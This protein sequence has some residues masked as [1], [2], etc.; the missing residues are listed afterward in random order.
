MR[1]PDNEGKACDAVVKVLEKSTGETRSNIRCPEKDGDGPPVELRLMLGTQEFAIEHTR[2]E[3]FEKQIQTGQVFA[4]VSRLIVDKLSGNLPGPECYELHMPVDVSLRVKGAKLQQARRDLIEW[5]RAQ[6]QYMH[7]K[8]LHSPKPGHGLYRS[9]D[10]VCGSPAGFN[11]EITL[12]RWRDASLMNRK[13]GSLRVV[14]VVGDDLE[15]NRADRLRRALS[16]KCPKLRDCKVQN[17]RTILV[18]ESDD[19]PLTNHH[20]VAEALN[21]VLPERTD[22]PDEMYFVESDN[23]DWYI[24]LMKRDESCWPMEGLDEQ[25]PTIL[26]ENELTDITLRRNSGT[27]E[28]LAK[29]RI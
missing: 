18:L 20:L 21:E 17:A 1:I 28:P 2:I 22:A 29:F 19:V 6:A 7:E 23:T 4:E 14:R 24:W 8:N 26:K 12:N 3:A 25:H 16:D 27:P 5:I 13:P 11:Y 9:D 10:S 15:S